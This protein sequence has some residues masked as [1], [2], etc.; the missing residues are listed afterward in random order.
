MFMFAVQDHNIDS[1]DV[2][3]L[4]AYALEKLS[5]LEKQTSRGGLYL[6][7]LHHDTMVFFMMKF[8]NLTGI[9]QRIIY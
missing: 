1:D 2:Y 6:Y 4:H 9:L 8:T 5:L 3:S 7:L